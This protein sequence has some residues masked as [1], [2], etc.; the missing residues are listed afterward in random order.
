MLIYF[1]DF[2]CV[3]VVF[4]KLQYFVVSNISISVIQLNVGPRKLFM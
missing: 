4:F 3:T 1:L 2:Y